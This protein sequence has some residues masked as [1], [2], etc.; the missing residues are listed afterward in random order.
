MKDFPSV[1]FTK[2]TFRTKI[3][4][5]FATLTKCICEYDK[6]NLTNN[7]TRPQTSFS[8]LVNDF[9]KKINAFKSVILMFAAGEFKL[10]PTQ[11]LIT[12]KFY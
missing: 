2:F 9:D 10:S 4:H 12:I 7:S 5:A 6:K 8:F 11:I 1:K 3:V